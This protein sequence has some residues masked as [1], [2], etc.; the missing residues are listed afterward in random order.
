MAGAI[1][2]SMAPLAFASEHDT[3]LDASSRAEMRA[4]ERQGITNESEST[5]EFNTTDSSE[6]RYE[7]ES[8][9][10]LMGRAYAECLH[11]N[12]DM[13][14]PRSSD[15]ANSTN[16]TSTVTDRPTVVEPTMP[17]SEDDTTATDGTDTDGTMMNT[18]GT[19]T[20]TQSALDTNTEWW[21]MQCSLFFQSALCA[22]LSAASSATTMTPAE[23]E[24]MYDMFDAL[25]IM[26]NRVS[27]R[28]SRRGDDSS[29]MMNGLVLGFSE[30]YPWMQDGSM[31]PDNDTIQGSG[32]PDM[33]ESTSD[34]DPAVHR[35]GLARDAWEQC[36]DRH[37]VRRADCIDQFTAENADT[38]TQVRGFSETNVRDDSFGTGAGEGELNPGGYQI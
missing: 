18:T 38:S 9:E 2:M 1:G 34:L 27:Q 24:E 25:L 33:P 23:E 8:C 29:A 19:N 21:S 5:L 4:N 16:S 3:D 28:L 37:P 32:D 11:A 14:R 7:G 12:G 30:Q 6:S 20:T 31:L 15:D 36:K 10:N 22:R 26:M 17:D 35:A 13:Q